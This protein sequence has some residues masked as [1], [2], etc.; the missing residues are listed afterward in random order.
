M[1][2][3]FVECRRDSANS[4]QFEFLELRRDS[5]KSK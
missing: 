3:D 4:K 2:I 1:V 5:E